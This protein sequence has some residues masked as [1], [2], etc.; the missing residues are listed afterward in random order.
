LNSWR[1][2]SVRGQIEENKSISVAMRCDYCRDSA[3]AIVITIFIL[4][5][6]ILSPFMLVPI[7][8]AVAA[9]FISFFAGLSRHSL[10][11]L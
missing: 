5:D 1:G 7:A 8:F 6:I 11:T 3:Q 2:Y 4:F 9:M 10:A